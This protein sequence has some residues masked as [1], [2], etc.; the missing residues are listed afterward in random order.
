MKIIRVTNPEISIQLLP[1]YVEEDRTAMEIGMEL[2]DRMIESPN[3]TCVLA[4]IDKGFMKAMIVGFI[5]EDYLF[6]WQ[7]KKSKDMDRPRL[8]FHRLCEWGKQ[9]GISKI[10]LVS[11][12]KRIRRLYKRKYGFHHIGDGVMEKSYG[13]CK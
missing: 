8:V 6:I 11:Q 12:D 10:K 9:K 2:N 7:A 4:A 1:W 3:D 5:E 13:Q